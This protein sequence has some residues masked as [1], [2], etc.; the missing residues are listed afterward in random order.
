MAFV[1][2]FLGRRLAYTYEVVELVP[3]ERLVMRI[4]EKGGEL[5]EAATLRVEATLSGEI[6][7]AE[8]P[9]CPSA[10]A[11]R[12]CLLAPGSYTA[13]YRGPDGELAH[14]VT[15][16]REDATL[17]LQLGVIEAAPGQR[18][19]PGGRGRLVVEAGAHTVTVVDANGRR[20]V[21]VTVG[22]GATVSVR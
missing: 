16:G 21:G 14:S 13:T 22:P 5:P 10:P 15:M 9:H 4:L 17:V 20:R 7:I 18:L 8:A 1:A 11:P 3:G 6:A 2:Q 19:E 12:D